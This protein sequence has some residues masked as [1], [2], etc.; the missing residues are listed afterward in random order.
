MAADGAH[1]APPRPRPWPPRDR[2]VDAEEE[3]PK[4][5]DDLLRGAW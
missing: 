4:V 2:G 1:G 5:L 3:T